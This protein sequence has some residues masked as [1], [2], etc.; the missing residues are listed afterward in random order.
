MVCTLN[1]GITL[2]FQLAIILPARRVFLTNMEDDTA[3][4]YRFTA[5]PSVLVT[6]NSHFPG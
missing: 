5:F 4:L 1:V 3:F 6:L 2:N